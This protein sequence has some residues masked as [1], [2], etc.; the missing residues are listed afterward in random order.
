MKW[1]Y[2]SVGLCLL[3]AAF[4]LSP[5]VIKMYNVLEKSS[6]REYLKDLFHDPIFKKEMLSWVKETNYQLQ[7]NHIGLW[8]DFDFQN[9]KSFDLSGKFDKVTDFELCHKNI[10]YATN[11]LAVT[12]PTT[13]EDKIIKHGSH[14]RVRIKKE[15]NDI[16]IFI[17]R[18]G[19]IFSQENLQNSRFREFIKEKDEGMAYFEL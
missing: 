17:N 12:L 16:V 10:C 4:L 9:S 11:G 3:I 7:N 2:Y 8:N 5:E 18:S 14:T 13:L 6:S 15:N 1:F 19:F